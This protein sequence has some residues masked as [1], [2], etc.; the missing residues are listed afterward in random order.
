MSLVRLVFGLGLLIIG[1]RWLVLGAVALATFLGLSELVIGLTVIAVGTSLP[2]L[3]T[4]ILAAVRGERDIAVSNVVGSNLFNLLAV[5]GV[6]ESSRRVACRSR[7][8]CSASTSRSC[9]R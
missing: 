3:A 2:E 9:S 8:R 6:A 5:L 1:S 4:S 7:R